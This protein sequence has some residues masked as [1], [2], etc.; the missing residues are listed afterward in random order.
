MNGRRVFYLS[1]L[2]SRLYSA[3]SDNLDFNEH[4]LGEL[5]DSNG[6][7]GRVRFGEYFAVDLVH[8]SEVGHVGEEDG[9]LDNV[10][11]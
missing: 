1:G 8:G 3:H 9:C 10:V 5:A 2:C 11:D 6:R 7:A 4:T